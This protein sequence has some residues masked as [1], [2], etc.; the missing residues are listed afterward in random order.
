MHNAARI[1]ALSDTTCGDYTVAGPIVVPGQTV[2]V[3]QVSFTGSIPLRIDSNTPVIEAPHWVL[4]SKDNAATSNPYDEQTSAPAAFVQSSDLTL[5]AS[6]RSV[7]ISNGVCT[8]GADVTQ[9]DDTPTPWGDIIPKQITFSDGAAGPVSFS[10]QRLVQGVSAYDLKLK[11]RFESCTDAAN[12]QIDAQVINATQHRIYSVYGQPIAPMETPWAKVLEIASNAVQ[13]YVVGDLDASGVATA[14]TNETFYSGWVYQYIRFFQPVGV[15][16]YNGKI[17]EAQ[18]CG[19]GDKYRVPLQWSLDQLTV[20]DLEMECS[21]N[22]GLLSVLAAAEGININPLEI[23]STT[24]DLTTNPY[25]PAGSDQCTISVFGFHAVGQLTN[26]YDVSARC[27]L[28]TDSG[29]CQGAPMAC[30]L[31]GATITDVALSDYLP[32]VFSNQTVANTS[33]TPQV[34]TICTATDTGH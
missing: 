22:A 16:T 9:L 17:C 2:E 24:G 26:L 12:N 13:G 19:P 10:A 30:T 21:D 1:G 4:D 29:T 23:T 25:Y 6:F 14:L 11:W 7:E 3:T 28:E 15:Y 20:G 32:V 34:V 31:P 33:A 8:I 27:P 5:E 18:R